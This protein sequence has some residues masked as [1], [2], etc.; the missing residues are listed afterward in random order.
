MCKLIN[1]QNWD[2]RELSE[3]NL[4]DKGT[5]NPRTTFS[6]N[7][8]WFNGNFY[9]NGYGKI[10]EEKSKLKIE[11]SSFRDHQAR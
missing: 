4:W 7:E 2:T 3:Y 1:M 5:L 11:L 9:L 8:A 10:K 6:N